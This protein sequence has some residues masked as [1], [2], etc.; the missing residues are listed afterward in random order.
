MTPAAR[1]ESSCAWHVA[2]LIASLVLACSRTA[3]DQHFEGVQLAVVEADRRGAMLCAPRQLAVAQS[4]LEFA[5]LERDQGFSS[6]AHHHLRVADEHARAATLLSP[7][8]RCAGRTG[9]AGSN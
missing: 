7:S 9:P 8:D 3:L 2:L 4:H 1:S 6:R 5:R